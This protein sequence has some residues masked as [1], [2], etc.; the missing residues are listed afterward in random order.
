MFLK[1]ILIDT[2]IKKDESKQHSSGTSVY[3]EERVICF[4]GRVYLE[5]AERLSWYM[6]HISAK[7]F[8]AKKIF[9]VIDCS[10]DHYW[11]EQEINWFPPLLEGHEVLRHI[12]AHLL[13]IMHVLDNCWAFYQQ[14]CVFSSAFSARI[15]TY[16]SYGRAETI[17]EVQMIAKADMISNKFQVDFHTALILVDVMT[18]FKSKQNAV[19]GL[20]HALLE[21]SF[22]NQ[23]L[24]PH[25][26]WQHY[27][28]GEVLCNRKKDLGT[29][30]EVLCR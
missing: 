15:P 18:A 9:G 1:N 26:V 12:L 17:T 19:I 23:L 3:S 30:I 13:Q 24:K 7:E 28:V 27:T 11:E 10:I 5:N 20:R 21:W 6:A 29:I 22:K 8:T 14:G 4:P 25:L 16:I 2:A